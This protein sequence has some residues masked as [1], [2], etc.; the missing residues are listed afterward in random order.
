[1]VTH[2]TTSLPVEGLSCGERTGSG[3]I[4]RLWSYVEEMGLKSGRYTGIS[5]HQL[6]T[7]DALG[8]VEFK[9]IAAVI[10]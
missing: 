9:Q 7:R 1:M 4:L 6:N 10:R 8:T 5:R 3:V 2:L